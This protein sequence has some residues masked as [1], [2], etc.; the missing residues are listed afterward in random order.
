MEV[1]FFYLNKVHTKLANLDKA[2]SLKEVRSSTEPE[3]QR[4]KLC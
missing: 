4:M 3:N 1:A 2:R